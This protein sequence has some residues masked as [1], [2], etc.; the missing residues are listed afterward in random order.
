MNISCKQYTFETKGRIIKF[1][2]FLKAYV[3]SVDDPNAKHDNA[4]KTLPDVA[5]GETLTCTQLSPKQ[6]FTK[7]VNRFTEA[8]LIKELASVD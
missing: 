3:E 4:E 7:P 2:G 1:P 5:K 8:S 6:H